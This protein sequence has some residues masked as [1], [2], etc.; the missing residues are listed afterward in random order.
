MRIMLD[1][2]ERGAHSENNVRCGHTREMKK[3]RA[4]N[5]KVGICV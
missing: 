4:A 3:T 5:P 1:V 2:D